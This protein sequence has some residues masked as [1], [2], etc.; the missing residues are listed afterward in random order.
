MVKL[1]DD[2]HS[3]QFKPKWNSRQNP[4]LFI[5]IKSKEQMLLYTANYDKLSLWEVREH[6]TSV[7]VVQ[8]ASENGGN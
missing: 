1:K 5:Q 2:R 3:F 8:S 7:G 6:A 4:A